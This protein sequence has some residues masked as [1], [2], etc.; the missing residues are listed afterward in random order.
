M[1]LARARALLVTEAQGLES[2]FNA[3][4]PGAPDRPQIIRRLA[5]D[6]VELSRSSARD[7]RDSEATAARRRAIGYYE[8]LVREAPTYPMLDEVFYFMGLEYELA[9]DL[10]NARKSYYEL[11]KRSPSSKYIPHAYFAFG[12]MFFE[13]AKA[14][15][16]KLDL[17]SQAFMEVLKYPAPANGLFPD[18]LLRLGQIADQK[19]DAAR[20]AN[21]YARLK[22]DFPTSEAAAS[23]P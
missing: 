19:G 8:R 10:M 23:A 11:I 18:A 6:F 16:S 14:D 15:P 17:A 7:G 5:E 20:A 22:R 13:E 2:L 4:S 21:Y 3:T 9:G 1:Q 12:E